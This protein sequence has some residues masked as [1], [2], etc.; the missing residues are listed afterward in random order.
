MV[1]GMTKIA[2][3][4]GANKGIGYETARLLGE[5]GMTVLVGARDEALGEKAASALGARFLR[6]DVSDDSS[7]AQAAET[8]AADY[9]RLD[10]L[11]NNAGITGSARG[12]PSETTRAAL[13][14]VF[15]TNVFGLVAVTNAFLPLLRKAGS[16]R[17]V[18]VSS[19]VGSFASMTDPANPLSA[20]AAIAYPTS[21]TAVNMI[22][23]MYAK[24]LRGTDI[25]VNASIPGHCA[26][27]LTRQTGDRTA[28]DGAA[29]SL[30]LA[31]L[32]DDGPT[33]LV[34]TDG[35][36]QLAF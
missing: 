14:Q 1:C 10:V 27:D 33:G 22:T 28:A 29:V 4:T 20:M 8:V 3:V 24:E 13:R 36:R 15:G 34:F 7:I 31:T 25:K 16:A 32:P 21:K 12:G 17:I 11:V 6:I 26:T 18:N 9:G 23:V 2:L 19:E 35:G 30:A 5:R